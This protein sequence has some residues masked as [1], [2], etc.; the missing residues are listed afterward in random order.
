MYYHILVARAH[1]S[2]LC[3]RSWVITAGS[4]Q[5]GQA[6]IDRCSRQGRGLGNCSSLNVT[7][8]DTR[9]NDNNINI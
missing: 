5:L 8:N 1:S 7:A 9:V 3:H 4:S 2:E 6:G